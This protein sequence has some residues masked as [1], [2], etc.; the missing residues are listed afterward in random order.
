PSPPFSSTATAPPELYTLSLHDALP[1]CP[2][3]ARQPRP[4]VPPRPGDVRAAR[5][6][7][8]QHAPGGEPVLQRPQAGADRDGRGEGPRRRRRRDRPADDARADPAA[9]HAERRQP[10]SLDAA[11]RRVAAR[12]RGD[13]AARLVRRRRGPRLAQ[14]RGRPGRPAPAPLTGRSP[15]PPPA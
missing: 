13:P 14:R 8:V 7:A 6:G 10:A 3:P 12:A 4:A 5:D 1:I 9:A 15:R 11:A 2:R